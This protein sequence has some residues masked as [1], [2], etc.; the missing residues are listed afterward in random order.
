MILLPKGKYRVRIAVSDDE[1]TSALA[2]RARAFSLDGRSDRDDY[3]A[4]CT[5]VLV[6]VAATK[7]IVCCF[8]VMFFPNGSALASAYSAQFYDLSNHNAYPHPLLEVG[9]FCV[10]PPSFDPDILRVAWAAITRLVDERGVGMLFGCSSFN[11]TDLMPFWS[12]FQ[13]LSEKYL[14]AATDQVG[15]RAAETFRF[16][17]MKPAD[18]DPKAALSGLPPLLR[19]YLSMGGRVSDHAVIDRNMNTMHVYT[20]LKI[21]EIPVGRA[22][23]LRTL[24]A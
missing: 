12:N 9:R 13:Y 6:E 17:A 11:G 3:D 22:R 24:S 21:A 8:R 5:H 23:M 4:V 18:F 1:L 10:D 7:A 20:A 15:G 19:S 14:L 2:L 16:R